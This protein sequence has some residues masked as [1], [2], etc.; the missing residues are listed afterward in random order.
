M[1]TGGL[2]DA[3]RRLLE[4]RRRPR[5]AARREPE[6]RELPRRAPGPAP[7]SSAQAALV[8]E[9]QADPRSPRYMVAHWWRIRGEVDVHR[10]LA[11]VR[12]RVAAH[13]VLRTCFDEHRTV[14]DL[15]DAL[16]VVVRRA[17][18]ESVDREL[19]DL[20]SRP[21]TI[22]RGPLVRVLVLQVADDDTVLALAMPHPLCDAVSMALLWREIAACLRGEDLA[23]PERDYHDHAAASAAKGI[24][25]DDRRYWRGAL[26]GAASFT[27][28]HPRP[29]P[30]GPDRWIE[31]QPI[32]SIPGLDGAAGALG[33][34]ARFLAALA[35]AL[36]D[37]IEG[38]QVVVGAVASTREPG[39]TDAMVGCFLNTLP[40]RIVPSPAETFAALVERVE[41]ELARALRHRGMPY[42]EI[43]R[44]MRQQGV[45]LEASVLFVFDD[46]DEPVL[47]G[48]EVVG[49]VTF[50]GAAAAPMS[51]FVRRRRGAIS[52]AAEHRGGVLTAAVV[53]DVLSAVER[54]VEAGSRRSQATIAELR[55]GGSPPI[56]D[57][58]AG[59]SEGG[60]P[61]AP[62]GSTVPERVLAVASAHPD[63]VAVVT[64]GVST[65]YG[66]LV[67][68]ARAVAAHLRALGIGAGDLVGIDAARGVE[69][70]AAALGVWFA[71]AAYCPIDPSYPPA[72]RDDMTHRAGIR[73]V[74]D[75]AAVRSLASA[76]TDGVDRT[77]PEDATA[78]VMFTS[79]STG[80]PKAVVVDHHNLAWST[81]ARVEVYGREPVRFL[82]L[83]GF[84]FDSSVAG[85]YGT[86]TTGG[87]VVVPTDDEVHDVD[88][89]LEL[90]AA[91]R[92]ERVLCVPALWRALLDR[93]GGRAWAVREAIV[94]GESCPASLVA[95]HHELLPD[96]AL[97]NEYGPT[98]ATVWCTAHRCRVDERPVPIGRPVPGAW[99]LIADAAGRGRPTGA[100]GELVVGG[101][102][103]ARGYLDDPD[104]TA[105]R[106]VDFPWGRGYRTGDR[107]RDRG[108][109]VLEYLGRVD[110][111]LSIGGHRIEPA[112][113]E[114]ALL[115]LPAVRDAAV[116]A[117]ARP[118]SDVAGALDA[119]DPAEAAALL[120]SAAGAD[121]PGRALADGLAAALGHP[122]QLVAFVE[123]GAAI[124]EAG[125]LHALRAQLPPAWV[126][127]EVD[128]VDELPRT[129]HGKV[130][131]V[132]LAAR[133]PS[134]RRGGDGPT[135]GRR[136]LATAVLSEVLGRPIDPDEDFFAVGG[137]SLLAL[138]AVT[139]LEQRLGREVAV[140]TVVGARTPRR[141][142]E[143]LAVA[144]A[145]HRLVESFRVGD[146]RR[147]LF[148]LPP[149]GGNVV[150]YRALA[151]R[152][153]PSLPVIG[154]RAP[155][156]DGR[157]APADSVEAMAEIFV[158]AARTVQPTGPLRILGWSLG[159]LV[160]YE[161]ARQLTEAGS[162]PELIVMVDTVYPG[163]HLVFVD[164][165]RFVRMASER[166]WRELA[167][168]LR[169]VAD[170]R[171]RTL[172]RI[173]GF[174]R[175]QRDD[176]AALSREL[177]E[178]WIFRRAGRLATA[179]QPRP[180]AGRVLFF[181]ASKSDPA[182]TT[183]VWSATVP[184]LEVV[185]IA[186][187]HDKDE[188]IVDEP[189]VAEL[190]ARLEA[191]LLPD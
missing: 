70:I 104:T 12:D 18:A 15:D 20:A 135:T 89:V 166:R 76:P 125:V 186:G 5:S 124:D 112:E 62:E 177:A 156:A 80:R 182:F 75:R 149:G 119:L 8:Y 42:A 142:D 21:Y 153:D 91:H 163:N 146:G 172:R 3:Q 69:T 4:E 68:Q 120:R 161:M 103:V 170:R 114:R 185:E 48:C 105:E 147:P 158:E 55:G 57:A 74:L 171:V 37:H 98:E 85:L 138:Q 126:P 111:Q 94:A 51:M 107:A 93:N 32:G 145:P 167:H 134:S 83:S 165:G 132:A 77:I 39:V 47:P 17:S 45:D 140:T 155:G 159:G 9:H 99:V 131:R 96:T 73:V 191:T 181:R 118:V 25:D 30:V 41:G 174:R 168:D 64:G 137:D 117:R 14:L 16:A 11:A 115:D 54:I 46:A 136:S 19:S 92:V 88:R 35:V 33:T 34:S 139:M 95:R 2:S 23:A 59:R 53:D 43:V 90:I 144:A 109:G 175:A 79:G 97:W 169:G 130:D 151:A 86:L 7:V 157:E 61:L 67:A 82:L 24:D 26:D 1:T 184:R 187:T 148:L 121:S 176:R 102:G 173:V 190:V 66:S 87:T 84:G 128:V 108:D 127:V 44:T 27:F 71:G 162:P 63:A 160:A 22:D 178:D 58:S 116:V 6:V 29:T 49:D 40:L 129:V 13:E 141:I 31:R 81:A 38:D 150:G 133:P 10:L 180:Y 50:C 113:I 56:V 65:T 100:V 152:L 52:L 72:R 122:P 188:S 189:R 28:A 123:A 183:D 154:L 110:E 106:F 36:L 101:P 164:R 179:Y 143:A 60:A 78:Y